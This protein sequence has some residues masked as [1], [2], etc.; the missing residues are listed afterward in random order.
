MV[1]PV[2]LLPQLADDGEYHRGSILSRIIFESVMA[3]QAAA[4]IQLISECWSWICRLK[5]RVAL[6]FIWDSI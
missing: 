6:S 4:S 5:R 2:S 3:Y 1:Y